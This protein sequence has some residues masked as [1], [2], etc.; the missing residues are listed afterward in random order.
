[1]T[2]SPAPANDPVRLQKYLAEA[3]V[4]S[5][6]G[7]EGLIL[8]GRVTVDGHVVRLLGSKVVPGRGEVRVDGVPVRPQRKLHLALHKPPGYVCS[9]KEQGRHP[10]VMDL[11][12]EEWQGVYP[13]G[14][15]DRT[16]EGLLLL[17]NDG[18][19]ALRVAH[20]R[21]GVRKTYFAVVTGRVTEVM[22]DALV[23][24]VRH[25]GELLRAESVQLL[26]ANSSRSRVQLVLRE[27]RNREIRRM[28]QVLGLRVDRL[29]REQIGSLR[30]GE[31]PAGR[32][33]LLHAR[34]V[35]GLLAGTGAAPAAGAPVRTDIDRRA[36]RPANERPR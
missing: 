8:E 33:R 29:V 24:G 32:W 25:Q 27:G 5:R 36:R 20:P 6:R 14:R 9:R 11:L 10:V 12:P 19:F 16:S 31:L 35:A 1:M 4:A 34:E 17:T 18:E 7:A 3:G 2:T 30:L 23:R 22:A 28:F 21:H 15:L 26:T 13:V